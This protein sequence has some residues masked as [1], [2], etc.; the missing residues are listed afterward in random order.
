MIF[1]SKVQLFDPQVFSSSFSR[2]TSL[3][4]RHFFF[5]CVFVSDKKIIPKNSDYLKKAIRDKGKVIRRVAFLLSFCSFHLDCGFDWAKRI[6]ERWR[7]RIFATRAAELNTA[8]KE[9]NRRRKYAKN[10]K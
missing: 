3:P 7:L 5:F 10:E 4:Y 9:M 2:K 6:T 1:G 8:R